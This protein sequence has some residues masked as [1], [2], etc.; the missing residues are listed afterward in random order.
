MEDF[1]SG[2]RLVEGE[3]FQIPM[4]SGRSVDFYVRGVLIEYHHLR[5]KVERKRYGDF[6]SREEYLA[7]SKELRRVRHNRPR[8]EKLIKKTREKLSNNY[9]EKRR[10]IIDEHPI[11]SGTELIV[12]SSLEDFYEQVILRF[13]EPR[14]PS[15][16]H[17]RELFQERVRTISEEGN[18]RF[19]R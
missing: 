8:R 12:A 5:L 6:R 18:F 4:G 7:Y 15:L 2:F 17:F 16:D 14:C 1:I 13:A 9:F 19:R 11:Y 10:R 3:T